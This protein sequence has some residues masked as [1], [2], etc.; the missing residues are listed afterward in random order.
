M[1]RK[2]ILKFVSLLGIGSFVM[3]SAAS[4]TSATTPTPNPEPK[5]NPTPNPEP[6]PMPNPGGGGESM[7]NAAQELAAARTALTSLLASK[8]AN[9]EMYSDMPKSKTT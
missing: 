3:L 4:C 1:K 7:D 2:N 6:K 5:P 8:N 9:V